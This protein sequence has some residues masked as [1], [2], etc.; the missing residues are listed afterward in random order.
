MT[1][2]SNRITATSVHS[3]VSDKQVPQVWQRLIKY[4]VSAGLGVIGGG[5]GVAGTMACIVGIQLF[6]VTDKMF[7]PSL[8]ITA[9]VAS[10]IGLGASWMLYYSVQK[11]SPFVLLRHLNSD[12]LQVIFVMSILTSLLQTFLF[13]H[14]IFAGLSTQV[15]YIWV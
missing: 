1:T 6:Y 9:V 11:F 5:I 4:F 3:H 12:N 8:T 15:Q 2:N 14:D 13:M 10:V 7:L